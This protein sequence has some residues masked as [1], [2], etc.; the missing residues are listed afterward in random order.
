VVFIVI[1]YKYLDLTITNGLFQELSLALAWLGY[2]S[3]FIALSLD[4]TL[5][6]EGTLGI[7]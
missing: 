3:H 7:I 6:L 4:L 2:L 1:S 5:I